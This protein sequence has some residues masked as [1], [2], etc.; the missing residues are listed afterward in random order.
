MRKKQKKNWAK[1]E[2]KGGF[3]ENFIKIIKN[4]NEIWS[5]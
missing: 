1:N 2:L 3:S 5:I 4:I